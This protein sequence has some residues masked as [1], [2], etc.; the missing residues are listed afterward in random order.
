MRICAWMVV[1]NDAF[2]V[3]VA[4]KSVLPYVDGV[5]VQDQSSTDGTSE[6]IQSLESLYPNKIHH[7]IVDTGENVRFTNAY[8]EPYWRTEA[9]KR[10]TELFDPEFLLKLDADEMYT[11]HFFRSLEGIRAP[12]MDGN[13]NG[14]MLSGDRFISKTHR[15]A[16]PDDARKDRFNNIYYDPHILFWS[17]RVNVSYVRN[18]AFP[19][20]FLHCVLRPEPAPV[21]WVPG[22]CVLHLHRTFGP[23]AKIFWEEGGEKLPDL[24]P[25]NP[26]EQAPNWYNHRVNMGTAQ[27]VDFNWPDYALEKWKEWGEWED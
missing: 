2:Y 12:L 16:C 20:S 27:K 19:N 17:C 22:I 18:P 13:I 26:K 10:A 23:K 3:G 21:H 1:K 8:N 6:I 9:I 11:E 14:L 25:Y 7:D 15:A 24:P 5:Y 4:I